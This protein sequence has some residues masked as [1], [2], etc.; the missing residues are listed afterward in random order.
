LTFC[1]RLCFTLSCNPMFFVPLFFFPFRIGSF[2]SAFSLFKS[3]G[4]VKSSARR[5]IGFSQL[6]WSSLST[7]FGLQFRFFPRLFFMVSVVVRP[8]LLFRSLFLF[9][10]GI[11]PPGS[12]PPSH[13]SF[14]L[15]PPPSS[16]HLDLVSSFEGGGFPNTNF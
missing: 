8:K 11:T 13:E 2:R 14:F 6:L 9:L 15:I 10:T 4:W 1:W 7:Y 16:S 5:V 3:E 12:P